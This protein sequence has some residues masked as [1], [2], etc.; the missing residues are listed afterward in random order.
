MRCLTP[1][2]GDTLVRSVAKTGHLIVADTAQTAFGA[3][4]EV[5]AIASGRAFSPLKSPPARLG[6]PHIP[7][8]TSPALADLYYPR[9]MDIARLALDRL[10]IE[11]ALPPEPPTDRPWRDTPDPDFTGPY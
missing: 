7:T 9:A 3:G 5:V 11:R 10:G 1:I 8:L 2:D 6:L 4:A